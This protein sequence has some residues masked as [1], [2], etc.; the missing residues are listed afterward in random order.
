MNPRKI[1]LFKQYRISFDCNIRLVW[2]HEDPKSVVH[3]VTNWWLK[4]DTIKRHTQLKIVQRIWMKLTNNQLVINKTYSRYW[5]TITFYLY[6]HDLF[7][8]VWLISLLVLLISLLVW[9]ISLLVWL[10]S[11]LVYDLY[12]YL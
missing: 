4:Q 2:C 11:L 6:L 10:V 3:C 1:I 9:L 12:L 7:L 5:H 8:L